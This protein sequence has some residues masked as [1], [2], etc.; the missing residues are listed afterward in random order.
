MS[1]EN[2][3]ND[4]DAL[5]NLEGEN[6]K[7]FQPN[8]IESIKPNPNV[9]NADVDVNR[10]NS[11][12]GY[13][14]IAR[15]DLPNQGDLYPDSWRFAYRCPTAKEVANF[16]TITDQDQ[17]GLFNVTEDLIRKCVV[18]YDEASSKRIS[19]GEICDGHR[20]FFLLLLR[21][22]YLPGKE[23][24][25]NSICQDCQQQVEV[26]LTANSLIYPEL[27]EKLLEAYDGRTFTLEMGLDKPIIFRIPTLE[28]AG[29]IWKYI[30]KIYRN[31]QQG[32]N[33]KKNDNIVFDKQF[34]LMA[35]FLYETG[36]ETVRDLTLK[37][38]TI[39]RDNKR[40][41][42]YLEIINRLKLDNEEYFEFVCPLCESLE[43]AQIKFPGGWK[44]LFVSTKDTTGYFD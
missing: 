22:Y 42:A 8:E 33:D 38:K 28:T 34:L 12:D 4:L 41:G 17:V 39:Q 35:P 19:T 29:R 40:F 32:G 9:Q 1:T 43:E 31:T 5:R 37:Y 13:I 7:Q 16:S 10:P 2:H 44:K 23:I 15:E 14:E 21:S 20:V 27:K 24:S 36:K 25:Y 3:S 18:I 26:T 6:S 11:V 30:T